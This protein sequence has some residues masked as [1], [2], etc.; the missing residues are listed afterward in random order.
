MFHVWEGGPYWSGTAFVFQLRLSSGIKPNRPQ[1]QRGTAKVQ[2]AK[3]EL[4]E[5]EWQA[6]EIS[7][8]K[9]RAPLDSARALILTALA[10]AGA[11]TENPGALAISVLA[12]PPRKSGQNQVPDP[13]QISAIG[14]AKNAICSSPYSCR[15][16]VS[17]PAQVLVG[18]SCLSQ[19]TCPHPML[20]VYP[21]LRW[22]R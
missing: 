18:C 6:M 11:R 17:W 14:S 2:T 19:P 8:R 10:L 13:L 15:L 21:T 4:F 20:R 9:G 7:Y 5:N 16:L 3:E 22:F 1:E 12:Y